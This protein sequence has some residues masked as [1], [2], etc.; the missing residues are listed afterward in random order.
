[1]RFESFTPAAPSQF[2]TS[3][4]SDI[5]QPSYTQK[6]DITNHSPLGPNRLRNFPCYSLEKNVIF[7]PRSTEIHVHFCLHEV[8]WIPR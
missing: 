4:S 5:L 2:G 7:E 1:M 3:T 8:V 6:Y